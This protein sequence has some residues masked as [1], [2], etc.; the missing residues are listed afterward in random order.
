M[1]EGDVAP[2]KAPV[3]A[4]AHDVDTYREYTQLTLWRESRPMAVYEEI[5]LIMSIRS[6]KEDA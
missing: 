6:T 1:S 4:E 3:V 5:M 2:P